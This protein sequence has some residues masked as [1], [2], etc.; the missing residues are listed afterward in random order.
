MTGGKGGRAGSRPPIYLSKAR[1]TI[2]EVA[3][4]DVRV[5]SG[6]STA[7]FRSLTSAR[8][9]AH[10]NRGTITPTP[11]WLW[12]LNAL[13]NRHLIESSSGGELQWEQKSEPAD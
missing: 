2:Y 13:R 3:Y 12:E 8:I 11:I 4:P 5:E 6:T 9:F 10:H 1:V 7:L